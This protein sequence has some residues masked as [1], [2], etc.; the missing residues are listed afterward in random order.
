MNLGSRLAVG[1]AVDT[2]AEAAPAPVEA[3]PEVTPVP[4]AEAPEPVVAHAD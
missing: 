4:V 2:A 1:E 3:T